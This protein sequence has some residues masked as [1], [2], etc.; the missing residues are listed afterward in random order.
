M[1]LYTGI[2]LLV[3]VVSLIASIGT[4]AYFLFRAPDF[5]LR[6]E[7]RQVQQDISDLHDRIHQWIR[8]DSTRKAREAK[9]AK[10]FTPL[11]QAVPEGE[12]PTDHKAL[13]RARMR[14]AL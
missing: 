3:A 12:A 6:S 2:A 13:L 9:E 8:R 14:G 5:Q 10:N 7:V 1:T 4:A 11:P